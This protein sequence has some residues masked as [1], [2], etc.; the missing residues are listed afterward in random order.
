MAT[1]SGTW[2][3]R[4]TTQD[5]AQRQSEKEKIVLHNGPRQERVVEGIIVLVN[6]A[7]HTCLSLVPYTGAGHW[8]RSPNAQDPH[9]FFFTFTEVVFDAHGSFT[10]YAS[11]LQH[12]TLSSDG[13]AFTSAGLGTVYTPNGTLLVT[14]PTTVR[15]TRIS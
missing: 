13:C 11:V 14:T 5:R 10:N 15:A 12:A 7:S 4:I 9:D 6:D 3:V 1:M 8:G 2:Q